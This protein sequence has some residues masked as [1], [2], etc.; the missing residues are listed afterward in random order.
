MTRSAPA[1]CFMHVLTQ[2][3]LPC[4]QACG[5]CLVLEANER[6]ISPPASAK[7]T[8]VHSH[9]SCSSRPGVGHTPS[10]CWAKGHC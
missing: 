1:C 10:R 6:S 8:T 4:E 2:E 7:I 5:S 9:F 3:N